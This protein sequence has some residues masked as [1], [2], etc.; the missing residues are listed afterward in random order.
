MV[1][2]QLERSL[3]GAFD[4]AA[5]TKE[6]EEPR[7]LR[8]QRRDLGGDMEMSDLHT[9]YSTFEGDWYDCLHTKLMTFNG[10]PADKHTV[11]LKECDGGLFGSVTRVQDTTKGLNAQ[12]LQMEVIILN[13]CFMHGLGSPFKKPCPDDRLDND[14]RGDGNVM[15]KYSMKGI[16][17][18]AGNGDKIKFFTDHTMVHD[19]DGGFTMDPDRSK[20]EN[21]DTMTCMK[22]GPEGGIVCDWEINEIR[23]SSKVVEGCVKTKENSEHG[24]KCKKKWNK[25]KCAKKDGYAWSDQCALEKHQKENAFVYDSFGSYYLVQDRKQCLQQSTGDYCPDVERPDPSN[26]PNEGDPTV[27][28]TP[29][30]RSGC[31]RGG[32]CGEGTHGC[33]DCALN[34]KECKASGVDDDGTVWITQPIWSNGCGAICL[35]PPTGR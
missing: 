35:P 10:N 19:G 25:T 34:E 7:F 18:F 29:T 27:P 2:D 31:Y 1:R 28:P 3:E 22:Y 26:N 23:Y 24:G 33:C 11:S 8:S 5:G 12:T 17:S 21:K 30:P 32:R 9:D 13:H 4:D 15:V 14:T 20:M 6:E 16:G